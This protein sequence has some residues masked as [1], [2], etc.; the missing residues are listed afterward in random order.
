LHVATKEN[1]IQSPLFCCSSFQQFDIDVV[2][3][4]TSTFSLAQAPSRG[5]RA[6]LIDQVLLL[7]LLN[8]NNK[9]IKKIKNVRASCFAQ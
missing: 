2:E 7:L 5:I 4:S 6:S 9:N 8:N 1:V 3:Q